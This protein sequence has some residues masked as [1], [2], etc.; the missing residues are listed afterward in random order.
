MVQTCLLFADYTMM[1]TFCDMGNEISHIY[2]VSDE[3]DISLSYTL[4][5]AP[6]W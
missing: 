1:C 5:P 3:G 6:S 2:S 4:I